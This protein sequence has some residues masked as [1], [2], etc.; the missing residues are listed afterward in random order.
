MLSGAAS[1][2]AMLSGAASS[3]AA[4]PGAAFPGAA[5][6]GA[7]F[8]GAA[9]TGVAS[10]ACVAIF[11]GSTGRG[12]FAAASG[13][14]AGRSVGFEAA[15]TRIVVRRASFASLSSSSRLECADWIRSTSSAFPSSA[16]PTFASVSSSS[17]QLVV[18]ASG[19]GAS[20][21]SISTAIG[22]G[23]SGRRIDIA[24]G[25]V[26]SAGGFRP[27]SSDQSRSPS[28]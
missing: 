18:R 10:W 1:S 6:P 4:F 21:A 5:F 8:T 26:P 9:F 23:T 7:A 20:A 14:P 28:P 19:N 16:R 15:M 13:L 17:W 22:R 25:R 2:G 27:A 24:P 3:N 11:R 12:A